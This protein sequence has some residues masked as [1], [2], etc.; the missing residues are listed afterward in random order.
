[1]RT[2]FATRRAAGARAAAGAVRPLPRRTQ[3]TRGAALLEVN[4]VRKTF[5]GLVAVNDLSFSV[6]AGQIVGLIG[7]NGAGKSTMFNLITGVMPVTQGTISCRHGD[8]MERIDTLPSRRIAQRGISRT[9]QHVRMLPGMSVLENVALG[10]HLRGAHRDML[11][12]ATAILRMNRDEEARLLSEARRQL[13]RVGLGHALY[14]EAGSLALGQ[15]RIMEIARALC[16][17]PTL[18][19]L[20][21][22]AAGLRYQEKQALAAL[23]RALKADGL[24]IL[25]VEHDMDFVMNLT[26]RVVVMEFGTRIAEGVPSEVQSDPKVLEAYLGGIE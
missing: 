16:G 12:I 19:L 9:F 13:E 23:L 25:L 22:P 3:P 8:T 2:R 11:G 6:D 20:D 5:G 26:D 1:V 15:Q 10:A 21:E 17:D 4:H 24:S 14:E 7:P 18:L